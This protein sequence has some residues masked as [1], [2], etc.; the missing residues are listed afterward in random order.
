VAKTP[1][2]VTKKGFFVAKSPFLETNFL[3]LSLKKLI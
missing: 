2:F 1:V 3:F